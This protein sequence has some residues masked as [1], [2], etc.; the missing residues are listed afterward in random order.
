MQ[1]IVYRVPGKHFGSDGT[2]YDYIAV[3]SEDELKVK[4]KEGWFNTLVKA[5]KASKVRT[6][7]EEG[8][9]VADDPETPENEAYTDAPPTRKELEAKAKELG[10][11]FRSNIGDKKL[12]EKIETKLAEG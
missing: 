3:N 9:Y 7:D 8:Q 11:T 10:I 6:R 12:R 5:V 2:T 4:L 1:D